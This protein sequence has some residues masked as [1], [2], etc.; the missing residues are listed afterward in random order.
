[1]LLIPNLEWEELRRCC[2]VSPSNPELWINYP[3][4]IAEFSV[5]LIYLEVVIL[6]PVPNLIPKNYVFRLK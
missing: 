5:L 6:D 3:Y 4:Q 2:S 1:M